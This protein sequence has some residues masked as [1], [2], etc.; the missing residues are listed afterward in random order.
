MRACCYVL[1]I[2]LAVAGATASDSDSYRVTFDVVLKPK[3]RKCER[4]E[5]QRE[6]E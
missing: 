1:F 4:Q 3:V 2:A 5:R 6:T